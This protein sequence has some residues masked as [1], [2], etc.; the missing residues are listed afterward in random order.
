[1]LS[2]IDVRT[3]PFSSEFDAINFGIY[4]DSRLSD[5]V[6]TWVNRFET[7]T[8]LTVSFPENPIARESITR[9]INAIQDVYTRASQPGVTATVAPTPVEAK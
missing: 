9:Y 3:I 4:G 5:Q 2:Y 7:Q 8:L 6:C 1:M